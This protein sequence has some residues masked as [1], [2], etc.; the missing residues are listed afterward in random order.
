MLFS[1]LLANLTCEMSPNLFANMFLSSFVTKAFHSWRMRF[2][3]WSLMYL[4]WFQSGLNTF[5]SKETLKWSTCSCMIFNTLHYTC[6]SSVTWYVLFRQKISRTIGRGPTKWETG[7]I[8]PGSLENQQRWAWA[9][10]ALRYASFHSSTA[11]IWGVFWF[12]RQSKQ[13]WVTN[14]IPWGIT[15][16]LQY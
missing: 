8:F 10:S 2:F 12:H 15:W 1:P 5:P 9:S 13:S 6:F 4:R 7:S 11:W 3:S 14:V 16:I